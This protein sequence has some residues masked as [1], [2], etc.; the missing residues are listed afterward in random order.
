[1]KKICFNMKKINVLLF[2]IVCQVFLTKES[3]AQLIASKNGCN[4]MWEMPPIGQKTSVWCYAAT[5][6]MVLKYYDI[7]KT[8]CQIVAEIHNSP[9]SLCQSVVCGGRCNL[10]VPLKYR[11]IRNW[12]RVFEKA[13]LGLTKFYRES[14]ITFDIIK[15]FADA[16]K[17]TILI[18][19]IGSETSHAI[20]ITGYIEMVGCDDVLL[21]IK[22]PLEACVGCEVFMIYNKKSKNFNGDRNW[23]YSL[24]SSN[25]VNVGSAQRNVKL[26]APT[27]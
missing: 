13:G 20:V 9:D 23:T 1:M 24:Y 6:E 26:I 7:H 14:R 27:K 16:C 12:I 11:N 4:K 2:T 3:E 10:C 15:S 21:L 18:T 22:D 8:Q 17:P 25:N 19:D 5:T